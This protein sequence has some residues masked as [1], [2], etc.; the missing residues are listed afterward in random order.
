MLMAV[1]ASIFSIPL[2]VGTELRPYVSFNKT[3]LDDILL[4]SDTREGSLR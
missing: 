4:C 1:S 3:T 2:F